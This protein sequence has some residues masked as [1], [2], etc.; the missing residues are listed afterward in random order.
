MP[1]I[2]CE[3]YVIGSKGKLDSSIIFIADHKISMV[4]VKVFN[5]FYP[6]R[7]GKIIHI[8]EVREGNY[9]II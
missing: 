4:W 1:V 3:L 8:V 9:I 6:K 7:K 2:F 5:G